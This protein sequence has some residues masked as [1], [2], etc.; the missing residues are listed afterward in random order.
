MYCIAEAW[1][2][3]GAELAAGSLEK[4]GTKYDSKN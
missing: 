1:G 2:F 3:V 4:C